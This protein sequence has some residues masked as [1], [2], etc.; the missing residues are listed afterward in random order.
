M[1]ASADFCTTAHAPVLGLGSLVGKKKIME[2]IRPST[3][4][5]MIDYPVLAVQLLYFGD[6]AK[7]T[8]PRPILCM[9]RSGPGNYKLKRARPK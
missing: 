1:E 5:V 8:Y 3:Y 4:R 7:A 6:G 9:F 2:Q